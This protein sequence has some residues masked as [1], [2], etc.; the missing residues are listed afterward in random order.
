MLVMAEERFHLALVPLLAALGAAGLTQLPG[1][2]QRLAA[3]P[4]PTRLALALAGGLIGLACLNWGL[5]LVNHAS[6]LAILLG[7]NGSSAH[8]NY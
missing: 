8:F 7:P 4:R 6:E 1:L 5:E 3:Q 2:R